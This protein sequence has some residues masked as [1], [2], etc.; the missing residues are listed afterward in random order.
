[1]EVSPYL[2]FDGQCAEAF[3][4]YE[5]TLGGTIVMMQTF[6]DSPAKDQVPPDWRDKIVHVRLDLGGHTIMGSDAP[7]PNYSA[8]QG[9]FIS[10]NVQLA[11]AKRVF[12][13]LSAGGKVTMPFGATFWSPGFG[14]AFDRFGVPW[15]VNAE[16]APAA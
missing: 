9:V 2:N 10:V 1:M 3:R 5:K 8:P 15:M 16:P 12:D 6:G 7:P 14:M 13:A 4:F 11:D